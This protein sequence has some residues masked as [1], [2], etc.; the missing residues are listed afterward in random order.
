MSKLPDGSVLFEIKDVCPNL[1][2]AITYL[3][4]S[5]HLATTGGF[6][7][8]RHARRGYVWI[9]QSYSD[10]LLPGHFCPR[11]NCVCGG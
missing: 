10:K 5:V 2:M 3:T 4:M 7:L 1:A 11:S 6:I 8:C 9:N